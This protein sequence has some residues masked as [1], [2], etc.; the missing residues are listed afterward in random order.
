MTNRKQQPTVIN[1]WVMSGVLIALASI[2][3]LGVWLAS[4]STT[5]AEDSTAEFTVY[6]VRAVMAF[7]SMLKLSNGMSKIL[8]QSMSGTS[9]QQSIA[10]AAMTKGAP[11]I[12]DKI[13][14]SLPPD[15]KVSLR[16]RAFNRKLRN[17]LRAMKGLYA[18]DKDIIDGK[19]VAGEDLN[20][21]FQGLQEEF[22]TLRKA[23]RG[24]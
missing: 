15:S 21:M 18:I 24:M 20:H 17:L 4:P 5:E 14:E 13:R 3:G 12:L 9:T 6:E 16:Y 19:A 2:L 1:S 23:R 22:I 8:T 10:L 7:S 11:E